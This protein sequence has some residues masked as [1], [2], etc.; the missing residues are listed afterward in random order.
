MFDMEGINPRNHQDLEA[1]MEQIDRRLKRL[2]RRRISEESRFL[3]ALRSPCTDLYVGAYVETYGIDRICEWRYLKE[4]DLEDLEPLGIQESDIEWLREAAPEH[5]ATCPRCLA[6][7]RVYL[8]YAREHLPVIK[9][10]AQYTLNNT[11]SEQPLSAESALRLYE[12]L[13][14]CA[15][16]CCITVDR[17]RKRHRVAQDL[18]D[19]PCIDP[20]FSERYIFS[21]P[22]RY[23][24][25]LLKTDHQLQREESEYAAKSQAERY[26]ELVEISDHVKIC[27]HCDTR[28]TYDKEEEAFHSDLY[29]IFAT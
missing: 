9:G 17:M 13:A 27:L 21:G 29:N 28:Y 8:N 18:L 3:E 19:V 16:N 10:I 4:E 20:E 26:A 11:T 15:Y 6:F 2:N 14:R 1:L 5:L 23:C 22:I 24:A 12:E 7:S 25:E